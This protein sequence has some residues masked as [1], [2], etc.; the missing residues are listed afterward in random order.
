MKYLIVMM[1]AVIFIAGCIDNGQPPVVQTPTPTPT[2]LETPVPVITHHYA[3]L[4]ESP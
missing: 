2:V 4:A 3:K 1:I